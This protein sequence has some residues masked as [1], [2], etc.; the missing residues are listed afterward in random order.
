MR[1]QVHDARVIQEAEE[2]F[3]EVLISSCG[4]IQDI[5]SIR[6]FKNA[7]KNSSEGLKESFWRLIRLTKT[8]VVS[9][10]RGKTLGNTY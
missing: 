9:P 8:S 10:E 4:E 2:N 7:L 3:K 6:N 1:G 5:S